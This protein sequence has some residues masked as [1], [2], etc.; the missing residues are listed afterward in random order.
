MFLTQADFLTFIRDQRLS[1]VIEQDTNLITNASDIAEATVRDALVRYDIDTIFAAQGTARNQR[2]IFWCITIALYH[3]Y[4]RVP[5]KLVPERII[6]D[7][8]DTTQTLKE[9][10][11]GKRNTNLP[12]RSTTTPEGDT[13]DNAKFRFGGDKPRS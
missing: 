3:L 12:L 8:N 11:D 2:V 9:I 5:D 10:E 4:H 1:M 13:T 6:K 7:Y